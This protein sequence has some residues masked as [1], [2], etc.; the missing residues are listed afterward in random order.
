MAELR[1]YD[2]RT[3][4][5]RGFEPR[6]P[7]RVAMYVCGPTV[8]GRIHIGNARPFVVF[9][10]LKRFLQHEGFAVR[11]VNNVT[12]VNDKIYA[13]ARGGSSAELAAA[14][15]AAY[16]A[17]TDR[18][19]LGRPDDEP[20]ASEWIEGI[21]EEI[22]ALLDSDHAYVA[23]GD[24]YF[25]VRSDDGYGSLSRRDVDEMD[26]G[27]G[28]DGADR[29]EDPLDFALWKAHKSSEDTAWE[30][31]WGR[32]RPGWHI[33]CSAMSE[34]LLGAGFDIHG[35]GLDLL[36][37]HHEN[38]AAQTRS[39][40]SDEL[41]RFWLHNGMLASVGGEKMSKSLG[42]IDPLHE[43]LD[44]HGRDAVILYFASAHYRQPIA[45]GEEPIAAAA[46]GIQRIRDVA[47]R[48]SDGPS[49]PALRPLRERFFEALAEDFNTPAALAAMW[50]WIRGANR[51][52]GEV[53]D[54]DLREML[55]VL[56]LANLFTLTQAPAEVV[57]L[58]VAR[59]QARAARDFARGDELR[60]RIEALG[61]SVR[62]TAGG[63]ELTPL[64]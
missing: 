64:P 35:G 40:R 3:R 37:P 47:R 8:Y 18:L 43:V 49:P 12:D 52:D 4:E 58:A 17:D 33:E 24:V 30:A 56:G 10:L 41:A 11:F 25:R 2:T 28:V 23:A 60:A 57:A 34:G 9:S 36:F 27:E 53:G 54:G 1:L 29:K 6:E 5:V 7:G 48:C 50:E 42:N 62:D 39:A 20:L 19:E 22:Q 63:F 55:G 26:Q 59:Q 38:E 16:R 44:R 32:G 61:W 15:T 13:A 14:M 51:H 46:A 31:P 21:V 45:W